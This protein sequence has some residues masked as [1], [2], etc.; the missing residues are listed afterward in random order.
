MVYVQLWF[1]CIGALHCLHCHTISMI[2]VVRYGTVSWSKIAHSSG[3]SISQQLVL[4]VGFTLC[5]DQKP[6]QRP[7]GRWNDGPRQKKVHVGFVFVVLG[8]WMKNRTYISRNWWFWNFKGI[9]NPGKLK[10]YITIITCCNWSPTSKFR[11]LGFPLGTLLWLK[12]KYFGETTQYNPVNPNID[13]KKICVREILDDSG[14]KESPTPLVNIENS[15]ERR[16]VLTLG[17]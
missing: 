5:R 13:R 15:T 4:E 8:E 9:P 3:P 16:N 6:E 17:S 7:K 2:K 12:W 14:T 10:D 11:S 1:I